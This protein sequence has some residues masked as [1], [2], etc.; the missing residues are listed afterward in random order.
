[1]PA[2]FITGLVSEVTFSFRF[3][4]ECFLSVCQSRNGALPHFKYRNIRK[5]LNLDNDWTVSFIFAILNLKV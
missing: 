1:M 4:F 2:K 3:S 5:K